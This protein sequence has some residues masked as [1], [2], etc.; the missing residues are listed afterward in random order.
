MKHIL[1]HRL[2]SIMLFVALGLYASGA[3]AQQP[4]DPEQS[5]R[6]GATHFAGVT[7]TR[8]AESVYARTDPSRGCWKAPAGTGSDSASLGNGTLTLEDPTCSLTGLV[9]VSN[10]SNG[11]VISGSVDLGEQLGTVGV[12]GMASVML[13]PA[14]FEFPFANDSLWVGLRFS[15]AFEGS[16][17][18][19]IPL[20]M[21]RYRG[22]LYTHGQLP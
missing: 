5:F 19:D 22:G 21:S 2:T 8:V 3:N 1:T 6:I 18:A 12:T 11:Y 7:A 20:A 9:A 4:I 17:G 15:G 14:D 10:A 13:S 16:V